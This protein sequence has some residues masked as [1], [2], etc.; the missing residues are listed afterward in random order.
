MSTTLATA[1][2]NT[3]EGSLVKVSIE[4]I[5]C[6]ISIKKNRFNDFLPIIPTNATTMQ[7]KVLYHLELI[8]KLTRQIDSTP[9]P[10]HEL[11]IKSNRKNDTIICT[12]KSDQAGEM[13]LNLET[14][15]PG[16]FELKCLTPEITMT[17]FNSELK[18]AWYQSPFLIKGYNVCEE[19]DFSGDLSAGNGLNEKHKHD[20]LYGAAGIP[21]QGTGQGSDG[22]YIRLVSMSGGWHKNAAGNPVEVNNTEKV[23]FA[24]ATSIKGAFANVSKDHSI[25]VDPKVIPKKAKVNIDGVG[26]RFADD[27][28]SAI[29]GYHIDNF[30]G[31]GK[32]V[33]KLWQQSGINGTKR[34]VKFLG[35]EE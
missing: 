16:I 19:T 2:T 10:L 11:N 32:R 6:S 5:L 31:S 3:V 15:E 18:E 26:D 34:R 21:M 35:E 20:F 9:V 25:A 24:Y 17:P 4:D 1:S 23:T 33:V 28:G 22:R 30:L 12:G 8:A 29:K 7:N 14:R 27:R 13:L